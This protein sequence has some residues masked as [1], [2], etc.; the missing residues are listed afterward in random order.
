M[1]GNTHF[2]GLLEVP[3]NVFNAKYVKFIYYCY[4]IRVPIFQRKLIDIFSV[5]YLARQSTFDNMQ[6]QI[7][8]ARQKLELIT[9]CDKLELI[10]LFI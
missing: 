8:Q 7:V 2:I 10:Y 9:S 6:M 1:S 3:F 4:K 5:Q